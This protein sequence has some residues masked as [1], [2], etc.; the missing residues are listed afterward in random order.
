[1][2]RA[3]LAA[4]VLRGS[5]DTTDPGDAQTT[6]RKNLRGNSFLTNPLMLQPKALA[7]VLD[8]FTRDG[9][10]DRVAQFA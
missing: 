4:F 1:M 2:R 3:L 5:Y 6:M 9:S 10:L 8:R 7:V